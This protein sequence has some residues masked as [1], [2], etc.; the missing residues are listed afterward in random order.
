MTKLTQEQNQTVK[1]TGNSTVIASP[2]FSKT[3][4]LI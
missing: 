4:V 3:A 1:D 2:G